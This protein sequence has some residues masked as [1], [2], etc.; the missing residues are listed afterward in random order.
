MKGVDELE[1]PDANGSELADP[2]ACSRET[3]RLEVED[4]ELGLFQQ[5]VDAAFREGDS[6][7]GADESTVARGEV[8][9]ERR[10]EA[11][12]DRGG[13]KERTG[14]LDGRERPALLQGVHQPVER[15]Q[16]KL[17]LS[18]ESEHMFAFQV[19]LGAAASPVPAYDRVARLS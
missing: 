1:R 4:D 5:R 18:D 10:G 16:C 11:V 12:G 2:I 7:A 14:R 15:T 9:Q 8:C 3:S 19:N 6:A 17:H 13:G